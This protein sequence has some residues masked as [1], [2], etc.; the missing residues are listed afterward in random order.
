MIL[1]DYLK[2]R[3]GADDG[4]IDRY[5][6]LRRVELGEV[7]ISFLKLMQLLDYSIG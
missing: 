7:A 4:W 1:G 3:K 6:N 2:E 5:S